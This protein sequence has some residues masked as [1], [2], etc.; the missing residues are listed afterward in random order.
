MIIGILTPR[1]DDASFLQNLRLFLICRDNLILGGQRSGKDENGIPDYND[2]GSDMDLLMLSAGILDVL[3]A[4]PYT[5]ATFGTCVGSSLC[6][7]NLH[8]SADYVDQ[9]PG[10]LMHQCCFLMTTAMPNAPSPEVYVIGGEGT[11]RGAVAIFKEIKR[12]GLRISITWIPKTVDIGIIDR[13]FVF[14]TAVEITQ[15]AINRHMWRL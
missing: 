11:M 8:L 7:C 10:C 4:L 6:Q 15:H 3:E 2:G 5:R 1:P 9:E 13:S 12:H 14:Q